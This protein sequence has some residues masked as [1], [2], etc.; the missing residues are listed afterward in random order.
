[1]SEPEKWYDARGV[2]FAG[3]LAHLVVHHFCLPTPAH[4]I[5]FST[6]EE[7]C[8]SGV[9]VF[10]LT[11][12]GPVEGRRWMVY[13]GQ[14]WLVRLFLNPAY[15]VEH[16]GSAAADYKLGEGRKNGPAPWFTITKNSN[17]RSLPYKERPGPTSQRHCF[18]GH[19]VFH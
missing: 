4:F 18:D 16:L 17:V 2:L 8:W 3:W 6:Q 9:C 10:S 11:L 15:A 12:S 5:L 1:M 19:P 13:V 7:K 14:L